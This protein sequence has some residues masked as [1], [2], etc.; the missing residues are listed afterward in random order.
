MSRIA[1]R[2][3]P[4]AMRVW[5]ENA[6]GG[7]GDMFF[8]FCPIRFNNWLIEPGKEYVLRYRMIVYDGKLNPETMETLWK[9]YVYPPTVTL[10]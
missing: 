3:H 1:N 9:N 6:N 5:P 10:K 8:E 2:E 4:E 7:R